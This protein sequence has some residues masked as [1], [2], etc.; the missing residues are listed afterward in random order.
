MRN[1]ME[2]NNDDLV[3]SYVA[4]LTTKK[5]K[6]AYAIAIDHLGSSFDISKSNGYLK[7]RKLSKI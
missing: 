2:D 7:W 1:E 5:D 3:K 6:E 4:Q